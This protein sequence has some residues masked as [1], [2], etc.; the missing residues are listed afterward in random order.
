MPEARNVLTSQ[1]HVT[2]DELDVSISNLTKLE[3]MAVLGSGPN[4]VIAAFGRE[5]L[6]AV[7]N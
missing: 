3:L 7:S 2:R 1:L 6:R 4:V 5:F